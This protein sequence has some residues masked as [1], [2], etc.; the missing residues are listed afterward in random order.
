LS[1]HSDRVLTMAL[2]WYTELWEEHDRQVVARQDAAAL[3]VESRRAQF[4]ELP[5]V[6]PVMI[7][8]GPIRGEVSET[9]FYYI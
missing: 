6:M 3:A 1:I 5:K 2:E 8:S 9:C 4:A 7:T